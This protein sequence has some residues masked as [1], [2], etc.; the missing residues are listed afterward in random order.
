MIDQSDLDALLRHQTWPAVTITMPCHVPGEDIR[1]DPIRLKNL[2][3]D[4]VT[5]LVRQGYAKKDSLALLEPARDLIDDTAFWPRGHRGLALFLS[6]ALSKFVEFNEPIEEMATCG[7]RFRIAGVLPYSPASEVDFFVLAI[8]EDRAALYRAGRDDM[9]EQ[10]AQLPQGIAA[11]TGQGGY[12]QNVQ[13]NPVTAAGAGDQSGFGPRIH[14]TGASPEDLR[15]TQLL[16][17]L[18]QLSTV[19]QTAVGG[20]QLPIVLAAQAEIA[21]NFRKQ[22]ELGSLWPKQLELNPWSVDL[23]ELHHLV[24]PVVEPHFAAQTSKTLDRFSRLH[25]SG[26]ATSEPSELVKAAS[27]GRVDTLILGEGSHLWGRFDEAAGRVETREEPEL[28]D[29]DLLDLAAQ[30]TLL[31]GGQVRLVAP[32]QLPAGARAAGIMRF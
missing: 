15:K 20:S 17:Y 14:A 13:G 29:E 1:Q 19:M 2:V 18:N 11:V 7:K 9:Q 24:W 8:S 22:S 4:A 25:G 27:S 31:N 3:N 10:A 28:A 12:Q 30:Q 23:A 16:N 32:D 21:G 26:R 5:R 6:P